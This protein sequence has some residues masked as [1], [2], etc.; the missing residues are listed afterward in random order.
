MTKIPVVLTFDDNMSLPAAV[1]ISSIMLSAKDGVFYDFYVLYSGTIP[2]ITGLD[3]IK[4]TYP[5]MNITFRSVGD[6]FNNAYQIRG[7]T[8]AAYYRLLA[9]DIVK[10]YDKVIY[11]DVDMIFRL[12]LSELYNFDLHDNYIGAV[13]A[14][15]INTETSSRNYV[16]SIGLV[17]GNYFLSGFLLMNLSKIRR[18]AL[19]RK[20]IELAKNDY[21]YQDQ[22]IMNLVCEG[23][24]TSIPYVYSMTVAA[25]EAVSMKTDILNT[26]Y[27][28]NPFDRDPLLYS[29]IHYNGVKPWK[30]WCPNMDQWWE[31]YRKSPIYDPAFYF[32]FFNN[33]LEYLDQ[34][35]LS[36]RIKILLRYFIF[37]RKK[38]KDYGAC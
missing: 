13:Y 16:E 6:V 7:I 19:T 24:I 17:P 37:G 5:N 28:Y 22:D 27:M 12:D 23:R 31:Y 29:N 21:K 1:C 11:A 32:S 33:K 3:K 18:D 8:T 15:G 26:K 10:E 35:S 4:K 2:R 36:K 9:A 25:F 38:I 34:L 30:D 20:F 14:L